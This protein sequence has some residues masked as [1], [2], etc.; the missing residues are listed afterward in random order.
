[1]HFSKLQLSLTKMRKHVNWEQ[2]ELLWTDVIYI[3][4]VAGA[5]FGTVHQLL[6]EFYL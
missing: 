4:V 1:M 2:V 5:V 6:I 3:I